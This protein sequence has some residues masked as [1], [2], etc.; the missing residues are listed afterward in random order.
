MW[1]RF[2]EYVIVG[3]LC[4]PYEVL[5]HANAVNILKMAVSSNLVINM[6][7]VEVR[8]TTSLSLL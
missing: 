5:R 6:C 1:N 2:H 3:F 7:R 8:I 4:C